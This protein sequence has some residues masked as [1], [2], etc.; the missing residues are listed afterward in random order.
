[1]FK[2]DK[3]TPDL[4]QI[5]LAQSALCFPLEAQQEEEEE[6]VGKTLSK[7][8]KTCQ[9]AGRFVKKLED[10]SKNWE[11]IVRTKFSQHMEVD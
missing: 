9:R 8:W 6:E 7:K 1:M 2:V 4:S 3:N 5:F 10:L 11:I